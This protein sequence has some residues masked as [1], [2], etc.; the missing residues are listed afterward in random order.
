MAALKG[1][2]AA[3]GT[4][5]AA[6]LGIRL[7]PV[8]FNQSQC[9]RSTFL[10]DS[11]Y[12]DP[13]GDGKA[14]WHSGTQPPVISLFRSTPARNAMRRNAEVWAAVWK[15]PFSDSSSPSQFAVTAIRL[16]PSRHPRR[17]QRFS[18]W[19]DLQS[20]DAAI[21]ASARPAKEQDWRG[22]SITSSCGRA[23]HLPNRAGS[24]ESFPLM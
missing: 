23:L 12:A 20:H 17:I 7:C 16:V 13:G 21:K 11:P 18:P 9:T 15:V 2:Q 6:E 14:L 4:S 3:V 22:Y 10:A 5:L 24:K 19:E 8:C 1:E